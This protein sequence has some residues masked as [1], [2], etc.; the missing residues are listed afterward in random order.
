MKLVRIVLPVDHQGTTEACKKAAFGV[1]K[2]FGLSVEILHPC[3]APWQRVPYSTELSPFYSDDLL[4]LAREQVSREESE[5]KAWFDRVAQ[6]Q[7]G[8]I[9]E[10]VSLEGF[11]MQVVASRARVSDMTLVPSIGA[12]EDAFWDSVREG[13]L[14]LSG[15]PMLVV[16]D[17][18]AGEIG[19]S[20]VIAWKDGVEAVRALS[21]AAPFLDK[22]KA[23]S[24]VSVREGETEDPTLAA[25]TGYL[26]LAGLK[27]KAK[28]L[29][30]SENIGEAIL[31]EAASKA[32][33]LLVMGAHGQWRWR[34]W[35]FG[36]VTE[37]VLRNTTVPVLMAH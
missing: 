8:T 4:K 9:T 27:V 16:P 35:A 1:A 22:A 17:R 18:S 3:A 21:A 24:L 12:K 5:A 13:A 29:A 23:I 33:P 28:T 32:G 7:T 37:H 30:A 31:L 11:V 19:E 36:G 34:E 2:R 20:V 14:I 26:T 25:I 15:R 10:F 6:S